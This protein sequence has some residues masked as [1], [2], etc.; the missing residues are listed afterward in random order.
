MLSGDGGAADN[1]FHFSFQAGL[2]QGDD[3]IFH[4]G[5]GDAVEAGNQQQVGFFFPDHLDELFRSDVDSQVDN[6]KSV[7]FHEHGQD[8]FADEMSPSTVP[9]TAF[10]STCR[11]DFFSIG[12]RVFRHNLMAMAET[13]TLGIKYS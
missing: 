6:F 11:W 7:C 4:G 3:G 5:H 2:F 10:P 8:V 13:R 12:S 1:G 9:A